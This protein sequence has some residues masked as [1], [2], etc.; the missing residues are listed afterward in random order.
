MRS[1]DLVRLIGWVV[2]TTFREALASRLFAVTA[3]VTG[4]C[5]VFCLSMRVQ[6][7]APLPVAPGE[8]Q[9]RLPL[10]EAQRL[11]SRQTEGMDVA[12][13]EVSFLFGA[14][15]VP[16][17][18]YPEDAVLFV[19]MLL[20]SFLADIAG[21]LLALIWTA[22]FLTSFLE[23]GRCSL[24]LAKPVPRWGLL[25]GQYLGILVFVGLQTALFI[26]GTWLALGLAT[27]Q[28][29]VLYLLCIPILLLHYGIFFAVSAWLAVRT[30]SS[31]VCLVG[32]IAF[33]V[34]CWNLNH[35]WHTAQTDTP[36]VGP[37]WLGTAYWMLPKPADLNWLLLEVLHGDHF[38]GRLLGYASLGTDGGLRL[39]GSIATSM[40]FA[41]G[42]LILA[43]RR[44]ARTDY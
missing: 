42:M 36:G 4:V 11:G 40:L 25:T 9:M 27:G 34:L 23:P 21:V 38:L 31:M 41:V 6:G 39:A 15:R 37:W 32:S 3:L 1:P 26:A 29:P 19:Q 7:E 30:R 18:H 44:F 12:F 33:W 22:G 16:Y 35:G 13:S 24:L 43:V 5:I 14:V 20:G 28:W 17:R 10:E 8:M 2:Y